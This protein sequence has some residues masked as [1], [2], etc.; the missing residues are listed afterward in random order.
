VADLVI[1]ELRDH[2]IEFLLSGRAVKIE[3]LGIW[4]PNLGL[5]GTLEIQYRADPALVRA[6]KTPGRF[7]GRI[8]NRENIGLSGD[9]LIAKWNQ[10]YPDD[11]VRA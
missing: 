7:E 6:L 4:T 10:L 11:P 5:D 9:E 3:G 2:I 1:K 8:S